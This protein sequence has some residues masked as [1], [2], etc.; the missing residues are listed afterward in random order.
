MFFWRAWV[1]GRAGLLHVK[2]YN[3]P[4]RNVKA[5]LM[6]GRIAEPAGCPMSPATRHWLAPHA[7]TLAFNQH[8]GASLQ[9]ASTEEGTP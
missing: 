1:V 2:T 9:L 6:A 3:Q 5:P 7:S 4:A 8:R